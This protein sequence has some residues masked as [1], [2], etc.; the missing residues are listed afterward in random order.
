MNAMDCN[1]NRMQAIVFYLYYWIKTDKIIR[2]T[3]KV[4]VFTE[5]MHLFNLISKI[6][7]LSDMQS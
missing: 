5:I 7:H 4:M 6:S 2:T 3:F 1:I